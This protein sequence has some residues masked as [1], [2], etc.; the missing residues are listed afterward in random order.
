MTND[1]EYSNDRFLCE[2]HSANVKGERIQP[3]SNIWALTSLVYW[4]MWTCMSRDPSVRHP[5]P[6]FAHSTNK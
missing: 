3:R 1:P 2:I 5:S 4:Y 6:R